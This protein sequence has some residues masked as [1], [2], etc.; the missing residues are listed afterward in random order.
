[1]VVVVEVGETAGAIGS[2]S[3]MIICRLLFLLLSEID[4]EGED[5]GGDVRMEPKSPVI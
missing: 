1:M 3:L 4:E 2:F 5:G